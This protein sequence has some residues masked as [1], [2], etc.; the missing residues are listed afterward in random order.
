M[1]GRLKSE[2][3]SENPMNIYTRGICNVVMVPKRLAKNMNMINEELFMANRQES[4][5]NWKYM[6]E[7]ES[8]SRI[9]GNGKAQAKYRRQRASIQ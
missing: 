7:V 6:D 4:L 1:M 2:I 3:E 5:S 8:E 9:G